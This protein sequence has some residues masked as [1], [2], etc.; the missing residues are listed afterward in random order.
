MCVSKGLSAVPSTEE[1]LHRRE[2]RGLS[3]QGSGAWAVGKAALG[4]TWSVPA[5]QP[6]VRALQPG[7]GGAGARG[8]SSGYRQGWCLKMMQAMAVLYRSTLHLVTV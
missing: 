3:L 2:L 7:R 6:Q 5:E 8:R 4:S 1:G